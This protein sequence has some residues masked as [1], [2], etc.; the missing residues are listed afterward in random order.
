[1][2]IRDSTVGIAVFLILSFPS[3]GSDSERKTPQQEVEESTNTIKRYGLA[4]HYEDEFHGSV[5]AFGE[6]YDKNA[7]TAAHKTLP[8]NTW[9]RVTS[10]ENNESV[11]VRI[12]DRGPYLKGRIIDLSGRAAKEINLVGQG[13]MKVKIEVLTKSN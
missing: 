11:E 6:R 5:T 10:L 2:C 9:V 8:L 12:N 3:C 4:S 7:L 13:T 1:M